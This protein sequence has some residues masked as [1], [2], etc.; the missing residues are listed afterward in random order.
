MINKKKLKNKNTK[1]AL[2]TLYDMNKG[3]VEKE[4]TLSEEIIEE[5]KEIINDFLRKIKSNYVMLLCNDRKDYTVFHIKDLNEVCFC[6]NELI[7]CLKNR[8]NIKGISLTEN[9]DAI[10]IWLSIDNESYCYYFF[11]YQFGVVEV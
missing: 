7:E 1:I 4:L 2:G 5:K 11:N 6:A 10:E 3:L 9:E 8:G